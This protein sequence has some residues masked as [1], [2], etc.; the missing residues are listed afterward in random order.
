[1]KIMERF[2]QIETEWNVIQIPPKPN[3][4][5]VF[6]LGDRSDFV[7]SSS[8]FWHQH[9]GRYQ[10]MQDL[11]DNGYTLMH[12]NLYGNNWGSPRAVTMA[13]Q[14]YHLAM[15]KE[16]L[17]PRIHLLVDGMGGL[18]AL[19]MMQDIPE[20]IRSVAML[21]PCLDL[22]AHLEK[23]KEHKFF[24]KRL[25]KEISEAYLIEPKKILSLALPTLTHKNATELP[26]RVWQ[27]MNGTVYDPEDH[28]K[29]FEALR[30]HSEHP[31]QLIY[32]LGENPYRINQSVIKFYREFEKIL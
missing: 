6:I 23:E 19:Q 9:Y 30:K 28:G 27:K 31:I 2:F 22:K 8:S 5:A 16:I 10:L 7:D 14:L 11:I 17:N 12:S 3:G 26:V 18:T 25:R 21:N 4:F 24:Y 32:H 15:K 29:K 20:K 1:M 13:K